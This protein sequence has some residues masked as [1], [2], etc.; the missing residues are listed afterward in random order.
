MLQL[1][2]PIAALHTPL[3]EV[4]VPRTAQDP[5]A[6]VRYVPETECL[7]WNGHLVRG[8][9]YRGKKKGYPRVSWTINGT[10]QHI[11]VHRWVYANYV[12]PLKPG[13]EVHHVCENPPCINPKHLEAIDGDYHTW[14]TTQLGSRARGY[15]VPLEFTPFARVTVLGV[16]GQ[17]VSVFNT[18]LVL[19][20]DEGEEVEVEIS[21]RR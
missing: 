2:E 14:V 5:F 3:H 20:T 19:L 11:L 1:A 12:R 18:S 6:R 13:E 15:A 10:R 4:P 21:R 7:E 17:V 8:T 9:T 16:V